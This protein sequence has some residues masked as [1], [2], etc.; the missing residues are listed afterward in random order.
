MSKTPEPMPE[1]KT[2]ED[3]RLALKASQD[4]NAAIVAALG[5]LVERMDRPRPAPT[6]DA[7]IE[8]SRV[9]D[10]RPEIVTLSVPVTTENGATFVAICQPT[11]RGNIVI[12]LD[13]YKEPADCADRYHAETNNPTIDKS[14]GLEA[15][16]FRQWRYETYLRSDINQYSGKPLPR[17]LEPKKIEAA[18]E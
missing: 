18:A 2:I 1:L 10:N 14:N 7:Q 3:F 8:A 12:R 5:Q 13:G 9:V 17:H 6:L 15:M 16:P 4:T 11:K